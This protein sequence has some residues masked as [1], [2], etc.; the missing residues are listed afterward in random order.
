MKA[1]SFPLLCSHQSRPR[2]HLLD[3]HRSSFLFCFSP[4]VPIQSIFIS[5][6]VPFTAA[7]I[8]TRSLNLLQPLFFNPSQ[9]FH[10]LSDKL[11]LTSSTCLSCFS[12]F[13]QPPSNCFL[14]RL[15][16][17][18]L[19]YFLRFSLSFSARTHFH[20]VKCAPS[21]SIPSQ[22]LYGPIKFSSLMSFPTP[23]TWVDWTVQMVQ[24]QTQTNKRDLVMWP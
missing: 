19:A 22:A 4:C 21:P 14:P 13:F 3:Y 18:L 16:P 1:F 2:T 24:G 5:S 23:H 20:S 7:F 8:S 11:C 6:S 17:L 15:F 10:Q 9:S 12:R